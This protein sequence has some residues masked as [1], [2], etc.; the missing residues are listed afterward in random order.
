MFLAALTEKEQDEKVEYE[1]DE[2]DLEFVQKTLQ[3]QHKLVLNEDKFEQ[4]LDRLEKESFKLVSLL[5]LSALY[6]ARV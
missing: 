4:I 2:P 1:M 5:R 3:Q 6:V